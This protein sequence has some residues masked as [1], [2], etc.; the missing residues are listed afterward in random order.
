MMRLCISLKMTFATE[1]HYLPV[2]FQISTLNHLKFEHALA[3]KIECVQSLT[4]KVKVLIILPLL[5]SEV[6]K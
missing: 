4:S 5:S 2:K 6:L 1:A 3:L